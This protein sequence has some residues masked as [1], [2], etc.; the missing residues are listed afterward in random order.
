ML[1]TQNSVFVGFR[2]PMSFT[3]HFYLIKHDRYIRLFLPCNDNC[4]TGLTEHVNTGSPR[5][6]SGSSTAFLVDR[7]AWFTVRVSRGAVQQPPGYFG[8]GRVTR[9]APVRTRYCGCGTRVC[10]GKL[11]CPGSHGYTRVYADCSF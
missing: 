4:S 10:P 7:T 6:L 1:Y 5:D 8:V 11:I 2:A 9:S 3:W